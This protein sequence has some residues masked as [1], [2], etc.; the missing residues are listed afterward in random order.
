VK[1]LHEIKRDVIHVCRLLDER[2]YVGG[3]DGNVSVR[4]SEQAILV[5]R[6]GIRKGDV[7]IGDLVLVNREG[8]RIEGKGEAS[9][10]TEMHLVIYEK[11]PDVRAIVH[12]HPPAATGF[13]AA[14]VE[15]N[16]CVLPEV[17]VG[18]GRVPITR[19]ATPGTPELPQSLVPLIAE[20]DALL[21]EN[22]GAVTLGR[23]VIDAHHK[24]ET[25]EQAA[26]ILL[27]ARLL[28]GAR[29]LP[30]SRVE[31]LIASRS[32]YGVRGGLA[33]CDVAASD[34]EPD[35]ALV[36]RIAHNVLARL[37]GSAERRQSGSGGRGRER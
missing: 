9:T 28:G 4:V 5:T 22:H 2:E 12:A 21:L 24:M 33:S 10:E 23:D 8:R 17:I 27:V 31:E 7:E 11:R 25:V 20:H 30:A 35:G 14:G 32:K 18:L 26:R 36:E 16:E 34:A 29:P 19:Y 1:P 3:R 13:A 6:A 15:L 37:G